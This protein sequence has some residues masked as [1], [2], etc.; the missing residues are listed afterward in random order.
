MTS[1]ISS[2]RDGSQRE[3]GSGFIKCLNRN[4][5]PL[6]R[7]I[8]T[9]KLPPALFYRPGQLQLIE[10]TVD[11]CVTLVLCGPESAQHDAVLGVVNA[12]LGERGASRTAG[13][14]GASL[15]GRICWRFGLGGGQQD[16]SG[17]LITG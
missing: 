12:W 3:S 10:L 11:S 14:T 6:S 2:S 8:Y 15:L 16:D 17:L 9:L 7:K 5:I 13:A 4:A 1:A